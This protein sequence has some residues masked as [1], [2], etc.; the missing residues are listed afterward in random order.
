MHSLTINI[1]QYIYVNNQAVAL[2]LRMYIAAS[3]CLQQAQAIYNKLSSSRYI[4]ESV[5]VVG[6]GTVSRRRYFAARIASYVA[7]CVSVGVSF[8]EFADAAAVCSTL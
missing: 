4:R 1:W 3:S 5:Y 6:V 7:P 8:C 2:P